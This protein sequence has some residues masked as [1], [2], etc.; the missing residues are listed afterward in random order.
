[1]FA[2]PWRYQNRGRCRRVTAL[3]ILIAVSLCCCVFAEQPQLKRRAELPEDGAGA[4]SRKAGTTN[5]HPGIK[6]FDDARRGGRRPAVLADRFPGARLRTHCHS[7]GKLY[8]RASDGDPP[9]QPRKRT[10]GALPAIGRIDAA[11][12]SAAALARGSGKSR[13]GKRDHRFFRRIRQ[14]SFEAAGPREWPS[15]IVPFRFDRGR[16]HGARSRRN[17]GSR[18][19]GRSRTTG[20]HRVFGAR[21]GAALNR[22]DSS[23][24]S[25]FWAAAARA[26]QPSLPPSGRAFWS[27]PG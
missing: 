18:R 7:R 25:P 14:R 8:R 19:Y 24:R 21:S 4:L 23:L 1:M 13:R 10:R 12:R 6:H 22:E 20:R 11:E 3:K 17:T 27:T 16:T 26:I 5:S 2:L 15:N 9:R